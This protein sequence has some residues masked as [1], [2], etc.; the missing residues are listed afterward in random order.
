MGSVITFM[1]KKKGRKL[2]WVKERIFY[3]NVHGSNF[4]SLR[5]CMAKEGEVKARFLN[6][7]YFL[8]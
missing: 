5:I 3:Q 4:L 6:K 1:Y 8:N 7:G 2:K